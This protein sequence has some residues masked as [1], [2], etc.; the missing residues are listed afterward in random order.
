[1]S[2]PIPS[3]EEVYPSF[4]STLWR[5]VLYLRN[6][7]LSRVLH[8]LT[9]THS[10]ISWWASAPRLLSLPRT[11]TFL[12]G[13]EP[14]ALRPPRRTLRNPSHPHQTLHEPRPGSPHGDGCRRAPGRIRTASHRLC[15]RRAV[16]PP[17]R[18]TVGPGPSLEAELGT[19]RSR[20]LGFRTG[21]AGALFGRRGGRFL[22]GDERGCPDG[23]VAAA[24][25]GG[26]RAAEE[27]GQEEFGAGGVCRYAQESYS[28]RFSTSQGCWGR[29]VWQEK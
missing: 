28:V 10:K 9:K 23:H 13:T 4:L 24:G 22:S 21:G 16:F 7:H 29:A 27:G 15:P 11:E 5:F 8:Q 18:G 19:R 2:F 1:M 12:L 6:I 14:A 25:T 20:A 26:E 3:T 17:L